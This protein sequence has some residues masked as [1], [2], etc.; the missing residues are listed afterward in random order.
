MLCGWGLAVCASKSHLESIRWTRILQSSMLQLENHG[1]LWRWR[2]WNVWPVTERAVKHT[3]RSKCLVYFIEIFMAWGSSRRFVI[4]SESF[5]NCIMFC[6]KPLC[7]FKIS[8]GRVHHQMQDHQRENGKPWERNSW[9]LDDRGKAA[10]VWRVFGCLDQ[11]HLLLLQKVSRESSKAGW[12]VIEVILIS[13][14]C[15]YILILKKRYIYI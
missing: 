1:R 9:T 3:T 15:L 10:E 4:Y 13:D 14:I 12:L 7:P 11:S 8:P 2:C 5:F 6:C